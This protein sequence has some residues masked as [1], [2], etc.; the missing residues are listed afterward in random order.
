MAFFYMHATYEVF[1]E[2]R[3]KERKE[4]RKRKT[5]RNTGR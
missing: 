3:K 4:E 1:T 5:D 2:S